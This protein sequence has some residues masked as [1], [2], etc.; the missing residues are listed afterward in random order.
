MLWK[1]CHSKCGSRTN[2]SNITRC[3]LEMQILRP[4]LRPED[5]DRILIRPVGDSYPHWHLRST[6]CRT[7]HSTSNAWVT[8][9]TMGHLCLCPSISH[10]CQHPLVSNTTHPRE[11]T[12]SHF[13][14][15]SLKTTGHCV[16]M[17]WRFVGCA[18]AKVERVTASEYVWG[19][20]STMR[21]MWESDKLEHR[22]RNFRQGKSWKKW[23]E[24][25]QRGSLHTFWK[26]GDN[27]SR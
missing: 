19:E 5:L 2:S 20:G 24:N 8:L 6:A 15:S 14:P 22:K 25:L 21:R 13:L 4:Q 9:R 18:T 7:Q 3:L 1:S 12:C 23:I 16:Q 11:S 17:P 10:Y 26:I 27:S